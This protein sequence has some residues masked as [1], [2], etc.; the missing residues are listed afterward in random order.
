MGKIL[1]IG[2]KI[3]S[4]AEIRGKCNLNLPFCFNNPTCVIVSVK[5]SDAS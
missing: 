5:I 1:K 2:R 3:C 4:I